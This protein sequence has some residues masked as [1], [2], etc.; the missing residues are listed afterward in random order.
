[1]SSSH[2][3]DDRGTEGVPHEANPPGGR[4]DETAAGWRARRWLFFTA[5]GLGILAA[6]SVAFALWKIRSSLPLLDG[7]LPLPGLAAKVIVE[8]DGL[9]VPTVRAASRLDVSRALGFLHAQDRFFQMDLLR[10]RSAG[11]LAALVGGAAVPL[12]RDTRVHRFRSRAEIAVEQLSDADRRLLTAYTEGVNAGLEAL[13][14]VPPEY[15][16]LRVSPQPWRE[17]DSLLAGYAMFLDLQNE[18]G[19]HESARGLIHDLLPP[20]LAAFLLPA[21]SPLDA[22]L[23]GPALEASAVPLADVVDLRNRL[24]TR[25]LMSQRRPVV[26]NPWERLR[27]VHAPPEVVLGSNNW[28]VAGT[29]TADGRALLAGDMHLRLGLPSIWYRA[30]L[31]WPGGDGERRVVGVTLPGAPLLLAGSTGRIAWTFTNSEGDWMDLVVLETDPEDPHRYRTPDGWAAFTRHSEKIEV[32]GAEPETLEV[33]ETIWG[34]VID[35]DHAGQL[36]AIRWTAHDPGAVN[37]S[38]MRLEDVATV[39]EAI[40]LAD[41]MGVPAQNFVC[42]DDAGRVGWT[43]IGRIPRR[44]GFDGRVPV[45]WADGSAR[46]EG[47]LSAADRPTVVDPQSGR[48]WTANARVVPADGHRLLGDEGQDVG[49]RQGQIRDALLRIDAATPQDM[50]AVQLDDRAVFLSRWRD[51]LLDLLSPDVIAKDA[52]LGELRRL[53]D[54]WGGKAT[55]DSAGYRIVRE[56]RQS[57][58][59]AAL[60]PLVA[61]LQ[62]ADPRFD[63]LRDFRRFETPLWTLV[64]E[65]PAHLLDPAHESWTQLLLNAVTLTRV[66]LAQAGPLEQRTWGEWNVSRVQHPLGAAIPLLSRWL[67]IPPRSLPGDANMPRVQLPWAGASQRMVVSPGREEE[68]SFH[69]P[70]G[71]SGHPLSPHYRDSHE[72]W[73]SGKPTPFLPGEAVH[74]LEL[75]PLAL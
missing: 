2:D 71:Q 57:V 51:L 19:A 55:V 42:V 67:D 6:L 74:R 72:A 34:P 18:T 38:L 14:S 12:D 35:R 20:A 68:G 46:W 10:R 27:D 5:S 58:A 22:P 15:L 24:P 49:G 39:D 37:L 45:S 56:W 53:V 25:S 17:A 31:V 23:E 43:I 40:S 4:K 65:Q 47:W 52:Q 66:R 30:A 28:A 62:E 16:A 13:G 50:L 60:Q 11:E 3:S 63:Y 44:V 75:T 33:L 8:R 54:D 73:A 41:Q 26:V 32:A 64:T 36:R 21:G 48:L 61:E 69:M 9:G 29:H 1:V 7:S 70:G 59:A